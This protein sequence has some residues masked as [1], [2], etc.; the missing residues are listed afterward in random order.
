MLKLFTYMV[1]WWWS[2][3]IEYPATVKSFCT[4]KFALNMDIEQ[5]TWIR[6][7]F[8]IHAK[9]GG[10]KSYPSLSQYHLVAIQLSFKF[11]YCLLNSNSVEWIWKFQINL[12]QIVHRFVGNKYKD[13]FFFRPAANLKRV[14]DREIYCKYISQCLLLFWWECD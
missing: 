1:A 5:Q 14:E 3:D 7:A 2:I 10:S 6:G 8:Y 11:F 12:Y 13:R 9:E 4:L